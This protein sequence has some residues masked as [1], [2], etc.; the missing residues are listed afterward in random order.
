M[1]ISTHEGQL[2][3]IGRRRVLDD[4]LAERLAHALPVLL[5]HFVEAVVGQIQW[6]ELGRRARRSRCDSRR[7]GADQ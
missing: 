4:K 6:V 1:A 2:Q 7:I 3:P 5:R